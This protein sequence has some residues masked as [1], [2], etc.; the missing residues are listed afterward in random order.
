MRTIWSA[1]FFTNQSRVYYL[2]HLFYSA[3][4]SKYRQYCRFIKSTTWLY[5]VLIWRY[6]EESSLELW[7][8]SAAEKRRSCK[9]SWEKWGKQVHSTSK[10][11]VF[12][13]DKR[14]KHNKTIPPLGWVEECTCWCPPEGRICVHFPHNGVGYV[15]QEPWLQQGTIQENILFG[16]LYQQKWYNQVIEACALREDFLALRRGDQTDVGDKVS[17]S[18]LIL[19]AMLKRSFQDQSQRSSLPKFRFFSFRLS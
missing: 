3:L 7:G 4:K 13:M 10:K 5:K 12:G 17:Q 8:Q 16:R 19:M 2:D 14:E 11:N 1:L 15:Q 9:P 18:I 6:D